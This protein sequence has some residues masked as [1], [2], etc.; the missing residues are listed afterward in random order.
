MRPEG[1]TTPTRSSPISA[2]SLV[3]ARRSLMPS[4]GGYNGG[5]ANAG[6]GATFSAVAYEE[7]PTATTRLTWVRDSHT[8]KAGGEYTGEGYPVPSL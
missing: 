8:F 7:K 2:V 6:L 1:A 4:K 3:L 5:L